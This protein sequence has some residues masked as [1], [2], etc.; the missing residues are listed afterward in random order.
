M[1]ALALRDLAIPI[2]Q[3][4]YARAGS[5]HTLGV[6]RTPVCQPVKPFARLR[7]QRDGGDPL[8]I[9]VW[10][11]GPHPVD[12]AWWQDLGLWVAVRAL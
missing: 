6:W 2:R 11:P 10:L 3:D 1:P 12:A 8:E 5:R 7:Y 4:A 9:L